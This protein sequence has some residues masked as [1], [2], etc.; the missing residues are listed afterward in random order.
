M[1]ETLEN[2]RMLSATL[3]VINPSVLPGSNRLIF[4]YIQNPDSQVPNVTHSQQTVQL[5]DT[6]TT[7]LVISSIS[8]SG[9]WSFVGAPSG[10]YV[11][12][13]IQPGASLSVTLAFTQRSLPAHSY[14]ETNY[15][16]SP[17]GGAAI[18]GAMTINSNDSAAPSSVVTLAGYWQNV[19]NNNEEPG[20]QTITNLLAGYQ[21]NISSTLTPD[22]SEN[23]GVQYYGS[24]VAASSWEKAV[25]GQSVSVQE[26]ATYRTE[27]NS[28]TVY[29]Y[30]AASQSSKQLFSIPGNQGQTLLPTLSNGSPAA[31]S[32]NPTG[33]FG[34]RV[35]NEYSNDAINNAAG[36]T[37]GGGH[38]FRF[39]PL[40]NSAGVAVPNT[41]IV[42]MD[43]GVVQAEN[44][45]FQDNLFVVS[46]IRP[47]GVPETPSNFA[48]TNVPQP[49]LTWTADTYSP[50]AYN[51]YRS[52]TLNGTYTLLTSTPL[53]TTTYTDTTAPAG[54]VYYKLTAVDNTQNP[55]ATS[56]AATTS[57]N[58]GPVVSAIQLNAYSGQATT[59]NPLSSAT[60]TSGTLL[61]ATVT[62]TSPTHGG[63]AV[64]NTSNGTIT[65][66]PLS[67]FTGN[68]TFTY[69]VTD[70]NGVTSAPATV[71]ASVTSPINVA[72]VANNEVV[73]TLE[74]NP[75]QI[76]ILNVDNASTNFN[77]ASVHFV[78]NVKSG[79]TVLNSDGSVTYTPS[80]NF[81]G[82]DE[83]QYT[84]RDTN[85]LTS[86][87]GIV[88]INVGVEISS[89]KNAAHKVT[90]NDEDGTTATI[91][92][93]RGVADIFFDG[94]GTVVGTVKGIT[95]VAGSGLRARQVSL[96]GTTAASTL[97]ITGRKNGQVNLGGV[98]DSSPLGSIAAPTTNLSAT[99][100]VSQVSAALNTGVFA[101]AVTAVATPIAAAGTISLVGVRSISLR[102]ATSA[103][104]IL[105]STGVANSSV[106]IAGAVT[107]TSIT[108]TVALGTVKA[109]SWINSNETL[110]SQ[111]VTIAAPSIANLV[112]G[113][114][115]DAGLTLDS[116]GRV[117]ALG[118][119]HI[120]GTVGSA[121][122]TVTG[123]AHSVYLGSASTNWGG[124]TVSGNLASLVVATGGLTSGISAG[125]I[126]SLKVA[127]AITTD[128]TTTGNLLSLQAGQL[129][130][131]LIA[132]GTSAGSVSAATTANIGTATLGNLRLTSKAANTFND[133]SVIAHTINSVTTGPVNAA[134]GA[135]PE[136]LAAVTIKNAAVTVDAGTLHLSGKTLLSDSALASFL[137]TKG[138]TLGSF[139]I[140]IL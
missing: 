87:T 14:N 83:F 85:G 92:L 78:T 18:T 129:I 103:N 26:L 46:N 27:G 49:V 102:S 64:V 67:S 109:A 110:N 55:V 121:N 28:D 16:T 113:G 70:S 12:Q 21:T 95:T 60:D 137:Q 59:F 53:T 65:Y 101:P 135:T 41:Y 17:N 128:I 77:P 108:S 98:S 9:P 125:S 91:T 30:S 51:V 84:V 136:G 62:V 7:P 44:F 33:A 118:N 61:P 1:I 123:N 24:E 56:V 106:V 38:H 34:L 138:A 97:S 105:G 50:V 131:S 31:A 54:A 25:A 90:Y 63:T 29:W 76:N 80:P 96:S 86:N 36:N 58:T 133:S 68:E 39:F 47:A 40:I 71:T 57:A 4:N 15:T 99:G 81:V 88:D 100:I 3:S 119:A 23:S 45:D 8:V 120:A 115:F 139:A 13:M 22:L 74:N 20:L 79:S 48:A 11:N 72:P 19:S 130:D 73:T 126:N 140:D 42:A 69:T 104:I 32:F 116:V 132:V 35:D 127:G 10:G 93:N 122:W 107:D 52:T 66:T 124:L 37:G 117:A 89:A 5:K 43:Y 2:R 134:S 111:S 82:G 6:G 94:I 114:V 112:I 75:I